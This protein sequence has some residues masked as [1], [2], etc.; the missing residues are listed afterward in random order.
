VA[1]AQLAGARQ[2]TLVPPLDGIPPL[3]EILEERLEAGS[4]CAI[5]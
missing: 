5:R 2:V 1:P 3:G 4:G